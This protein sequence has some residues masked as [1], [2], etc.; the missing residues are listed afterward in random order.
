MRQRHRQGFSSL[1]PSPGRGNFASAHRVRRGGVIG[2]PYG[3]CWPVAEAEGSDIVIIAGELGLAR[4]RPTIFRVLALRERYGRVALPIT[5][6]DAL[7]AAS[8]KAA[9]ARVRPDAS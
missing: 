6:A 2:V 7:D 3:S 8:V 9:I 1:P 5:A 4:L